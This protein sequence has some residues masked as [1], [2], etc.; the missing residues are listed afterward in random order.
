MRIR[1]DIDEDLLNRAMALSPGKTKDEVVNEALA[2][3]VQRHS[4]EAEHRKPDTDN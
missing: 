4:E 2:L 1:L 3:Y